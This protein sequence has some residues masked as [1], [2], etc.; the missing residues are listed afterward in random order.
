MTAGDLI[1]LHLVDQEDIHQIQG[2]R[3]QRFFKGRGVHGD[4]HSRRFC[5]AEYVIQTVDLVLQ[6]EHIPRLE[7]A[8][9]PVDVFFR[10]GLVGS[11][12]DHDGV[13][14][15]L[16]HIDESHAGGGVLQKIQVVVVNVV[17]PQEAPQGGILHT[18]VSGEVDFVAGFRQSHRLIQALSAPALPEAPGQDRLPFLR[19]VIHSV[20]LIHID[21][22]HAK[23][24]HTLTSLSFPVL[25][26][27]CYPAGSI[28]PPGGYFC[29]TPDSRRSGPS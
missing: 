24:L 27:G 29:P 14:A 10:E 21:G 15:V 1:A 25:S 2:Q 18:G 7:P 11:A 8:Q 9:H 23:D 4:L 17:L 28:P 13:L 3:F 5:P 19:D 12:V 20:G 6:E 26:Y 16:V 22:A